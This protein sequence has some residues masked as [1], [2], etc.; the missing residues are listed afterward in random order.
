MSVFKKGNNK[1][2]Y[3]FQLNG[4]EYY[5]AC[6]DS[7]FE[8]GETAQNFIYVLEEYSAVYLKKKDQINNLFNEIKEIKKLRV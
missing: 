8:G 7:L 2:Y 1:W 3:R 4:K 5:R 6:M